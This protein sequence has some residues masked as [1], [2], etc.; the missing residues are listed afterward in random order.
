M[1]CQRQKAVR[2]V[3][4]G[5]KDG[6]SVFQSENIFLSLVLAILKTTK[7]CKKSETDKSSVLFY[8]KSI[9]KIIV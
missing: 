2:N 6:F 1:N 8:L 3:L 5:K 4:L 7:I 9:K